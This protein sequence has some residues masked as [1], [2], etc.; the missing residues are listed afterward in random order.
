MSRT[1][2]GTKIALPSVC[3]GMGM[4]VSVDSCFASR[5]LELWIQRR[6]AL[7][8]RYT[9]GERERERGEET[10]ELL[11]QKADA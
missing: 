4:G 1:Q 7:S 6:S 11:A 8:Y 2:Q 9:E 3:I 5:P 10:S